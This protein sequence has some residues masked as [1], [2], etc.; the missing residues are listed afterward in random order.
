MAPSRANEFDAQDE[1]NRHP[2]AR[3]V[4][5]C[6]VVVIVIAV[7]LIAAFS[8]MTYTQVRKLT[9]QAYTPTPAGPLPTTTFQK[10]TIKTSSGYW[11]DVNGRWVASLI[12]QQTFSY[13]GMFLT[14]D[15]TGRSIQVP[16]SGNTK[17][18]VVVPSN[19][20][21]S[22]VTLP[23]SNVS[24]GNF[25]FYIDSSG[26]MFFSPT[27][28]N[29]SQQRVIDRGTVLQLQTEVTGTSGPTLTIAST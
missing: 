18:A 15:Q 13:D 1:L 28:T 6:I 2:S 26:N 27:L 21:L 23:A 22:F 9:N 24:R 17:D 20:I 16:V 8:V 11:N 29:N 10:S 3:I 5:I 19:A 14:C 4:I 12:A 7:I 25:I